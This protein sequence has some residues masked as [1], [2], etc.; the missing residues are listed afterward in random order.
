MKKLLV[1]CLLFAIAC[2]PAAAEAP[3]LSGLSY[4]ELVQLRD[5]INLAIWNSQEWQEVIV[6]PGVW[7]IGVD[8]PAGH[9]T[10]KPYPGSFVAVA[11]CDKL[12]QYGKNVGLGWT[13]WSGTLTAF[14]EDDITAN[15][16]R[17]VDLV[18]AEGMYF[19]NGGRVIFST[20]AGKPDLGF[21]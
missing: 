1:L 14:G 7:Q 10:V 11:Y 19:I 18:M 5:Q 4:D 20:Y 13:G 21:R 8:I 3:D 15:E 16:P 9:W 6:P 2:S 12:D 17:E